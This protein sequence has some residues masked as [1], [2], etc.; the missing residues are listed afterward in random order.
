M[1]Q[2]LAAILPSNVLATAAAFFKRLGFT[3][4][5]ANPDDYRMLSDGQGGF[6]HLNNAPAGWLKPGANPFGLSICIARTSMRSQP[7][8]PVKPWNRRGPATNP[9]ACMSSRSTD[10]TTP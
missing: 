7:S 2:P 4:D 10:P 1:D 9:G 5:E 6:I 8:S 3:R